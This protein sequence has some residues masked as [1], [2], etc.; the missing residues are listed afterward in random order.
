MKKRVIRYY[1]KFTP[2]GNGGYRIFFEN[3]PNYL[4]GNLDAVSFAALA[5][6]LAQK[7]V[8]YDT[9]ERTFYCQDNVEI[10][11]PLQGF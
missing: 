1:L 5:V 8:V 9:A 7:N 2:G 10:L 4:D 11:P 6:V 3:D